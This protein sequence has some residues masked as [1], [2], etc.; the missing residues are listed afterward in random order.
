[1][2]VLLLT[3]EKDHPEEIAFVQSFFEHGLRRLHLR[4]PAYMPEDHRRYLDKVGAQYHPYIVLHSCFELAKEYNIDGVHLNT[5]M[6]QDATPASRFTGCNNLSA[7]FHAW[8]EIIQDRT[9]YRYVFI[10]PVFDRIS[11]KGYEA[12]I[13]ITA[14]GA[15]RKKKQEEQ[16]YCPQLVG[17]GGVSAGNI[18]QLAACGFDGAAVL[19]SIWEA[20][21]PMRAFEQVMKAADD[22]CRR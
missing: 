14:A 12:A 19:G 2:Q 7:S 15:Q 9:P 1:M 22:E 11:K 5:A 18:Q 17:L 3:P 16:D 10:S 20:A 4:K 8:D 21:D 13:D 6:R